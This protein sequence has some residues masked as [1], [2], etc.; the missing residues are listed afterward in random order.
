MRVFSV[1]LMMGCSGKSSVPCMDG[2]QR[3]A[4]DHC[5]F[6]E[7]EDTGDED[8]APMACS[9]PNLI[10]VARFDRA[11]LYASASPTDPSVLG[12]C[13]WG[14]AAVDLNEDG[15]T[16]LLLAGAYDSTIALVNSAGTLQ[17]NSSITFDGG[18]LP[19]GNA[20]A[21]GD[22][23]GDGRPDVVLARSVGFTDL[24][25]FNQGGG[26]FESIELPDSDW[27]SQTPTVFDV[28]QDGDL[29]LFVARHLDLDETDTAALSAR[30]VR[31]DP[32]RLYINEGGQFEVGPAVGQADAATFQGAPL[33]ADGDGD[34]D[35]FLGNDF[36]M[37]IEPNALMLN[38]GTGAFTEAED[39]GCDLAMF[40]MGLSVSDANND[41]FPDL[42]V[43]DFGSPRLL[44]G[45]GSAQFY[46][47]AVAAGAFVEPSEEHV[48]SWGTSF[49][50]LDLDGWDEI[51]TV[52]GPVMMGFPGDWSDGA[53]DAAIAD[54]D[55]SSVQ[56]DMILGNQEGSFTDISESLNFNQSDV[57]RALVVA[58]FNQDGLPD[59]ATAGMTA[60]MH[61]YVQIWAGAG[62][63]GPGV[64][65]G[66]PEM[67]AQDIGTKVEWR[68]GGEDR[69]RWF[70]PSTTYSSSGPGLQ[71]GLAG[72]PA[73][74]WVRITPL[75]GEPQEYT[76]VSVGTHI[77]QRSYQ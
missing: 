12:S 56:Q 45:M 16:D 8:E 67:S 42:H 14:L 58:D 11:E 68:V 75:G 52:F 50:D 20:L 23:N 7:G 34:L 40:S 36:G 60:A 24:V 33:D 61:P 19:Q 63:C 69:V 74:E 47:G 30:T 39:C 17:P 55:D 54:L 9:A 3:D 76:E 13:G 51:A 28:D 31:A 32:N 37:F 43:T 72:Y 59:L 29:D 65:V 46:D 77:V 44:M 4:D 66:F 18:A 41:S 49:V 5:S 21:V 48:T 10:D 35:I 2:T 53:S 25:F 22:L 70:L 71:I 73:A 62:G 26:Q 15:Q 6:P 1:L 38:D 64:T 57:G 27:E